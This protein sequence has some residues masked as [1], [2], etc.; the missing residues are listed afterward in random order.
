MCVQSGEAYSRPLRAL[1]PS[2][3]VCAL[4]TPSRPPCPLHTPCAELPGTRRGPPLAT[5]AEASRGC[6]TC[7]CEEDARASLDVHVGVGVA[8]KE[9]LA[10]LSCPR[11]PA[12]AARPHALP[13]HTLSIALCH[14]YLIAMCA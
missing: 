7:A 13:P 12:R 4:F 5:L 1:H 3:W 10:V 8:E 2:G 9:T 6:F 11:L 14:C